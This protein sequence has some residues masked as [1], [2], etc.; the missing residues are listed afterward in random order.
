[1]IVIFAPHYISIK[2]KIN[3]VIY[4]FKSLIEKCNKL[5]I[6]LV[7]DSR[8]QYVYVAGSILW[9]EVLSISCIWL[10]EKWFRLKYCIPHHLTNI[11]QKLPRAKACDESLVTQALMYWAITSRTDSLCMCQICMTSSLHEKE[12]MKKNMILFIC[13]NTWKTDLGSHN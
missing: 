2:N 3:R 11:W 1:M 12:N 5:H 8:Q 4:T 10:S 13:P 7:G 9:L 6:P